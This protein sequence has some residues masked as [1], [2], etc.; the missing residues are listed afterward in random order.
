VHLFQELIVRKW[1]GYLDRQQ[2]AQRR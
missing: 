2:P 1:E